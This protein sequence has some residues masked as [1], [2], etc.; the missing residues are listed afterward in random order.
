M[1][2][3]YLKSLMMAGKSDTRNETHQN[4]SKTNGPGQDIMLQR[5]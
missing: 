2:L 5:Y 3:N 4:E 1:H